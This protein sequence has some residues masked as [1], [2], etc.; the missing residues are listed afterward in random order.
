MTTNIDPLQ[1]AGTPPVQAPPPAASPVA[2]DFRATLG[3]AQD[4]Q[5]PAGDSSGSDGPPPELAAEMA[6][7]SR[8]W[9]S[10]AASGRE[11]HFQET[12]GHVQVSMHSL[13]GERIAVL[14]LSDLYALI[15]HEGAA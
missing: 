8:T 1:P 11:L 9:D 13:A 2:G 7:A 14:Q 3:R 12:G 4:A 6:A 10:L 15:E 5:A